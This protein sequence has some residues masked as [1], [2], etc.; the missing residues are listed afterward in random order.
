VSLVDQNLEALSGAPDVDGYAHGFVLTITLWH[1]DAGSGRRPPHQLPTHARQQKEPLRSSGKAD[2]Y[3]FEL[4]RR[5]VP[6]SPF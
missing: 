3:A 4:P 5:D 2:Y 1:F 6:K